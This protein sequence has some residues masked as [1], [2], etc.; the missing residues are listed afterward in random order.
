MEKRWITSV[1]LLLRIAAPETQK[2]RRTI[3]PLR[4]GGAISMQTAAMHHLSEQRVMAAE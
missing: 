4:L 2:L 1:I 3:E